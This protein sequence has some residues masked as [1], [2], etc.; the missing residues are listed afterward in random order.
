MKREAD[1]GRGPICFVPSIRTVVRPCQVRA[2][3]RCGWSRSARAGADSRHIVNLRVSRQFGLGGGRGFV[4]E[5][6]A[7]NEPG[8]ER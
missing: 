8:R 3:S 1:L 5:I 2:A 4:A 7:F 6:D